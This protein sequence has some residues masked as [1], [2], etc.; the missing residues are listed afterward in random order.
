MKIVDIETE[1]KSSYYDMKRK[2][3]GKYVIRIHLLL[4]L[5]FFGN[6]QKHFCIH[7]SIRSAIDAYIHIPSD[8]YYVKSK[9][10]RM[11]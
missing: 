5:L 3:R 1:G 8:G 4:L 6:W 11:D 7:P 10:R 9:E 2:Y